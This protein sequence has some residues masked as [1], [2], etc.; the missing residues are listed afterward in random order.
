[1]PEREEMKFV[2]PR[3]I[4]ITVEKLDGSSAKLSCEH[5]TTEMVREIGKAAET[6]ERDGAK[7]LCQQMATFFGGKHED[8]KEYDARVITQVI[9][10]MT[11]QIKNP[12]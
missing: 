8:Y 5:I 2:N 1:M 3:R 4:E 6:A 10:W 7:A 9:R 11:E 12:T